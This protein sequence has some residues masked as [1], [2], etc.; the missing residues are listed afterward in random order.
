MQVAD[1]AHGLRTEEDGKVNTSH[2]I[3]I[4]IFFFLFR[5][6]KRYNTLQCFLGVGSL[7]PFTREDAKNS[8]WVSHLPK[9]T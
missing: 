5:V 1:P 9:V 6:N 8:A 2:D 3:R 4:S 7:S